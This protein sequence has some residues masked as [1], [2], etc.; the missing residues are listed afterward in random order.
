MRRIKEETSAVLLQSGLDEKWWADSMD[1]YRY[2]RNI[3][4]PLADGKTPCERRFGVPFNG[5]VVPL[6]AKVEYLPYFCWRPVATASMRSKSPA[7]I[8]LGCALHV[9]ESGKETSWSQTLRNWNR[10]THL[11]SMQKDSMQR[12][13]YCQWVVKSLYSQSQMER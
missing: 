9:G 10:W 4:D 1:C 11:R 3:Q 8:F 6:R 7:S 13:C 2:L 5:P 12:K